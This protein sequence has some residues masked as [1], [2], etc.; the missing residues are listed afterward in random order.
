MIK[1][2]I[3]EYYRWS[4]I[5]IIHLLLSLFVIVLAH[6]VFL[7][8]ITMTISASLLVLTYFFTKVHSRFAY[9]LNVFSTA[10]LG[11]L[12]IAINMVVTG[13]LMLFMLVPLALY[14]AWYIYHYQIYPEDFT[15]QIHN[16]GFLNTKYSIITCLLLCLFIGGGGFI[17]GLTGL[18]VYPFID[19]GIIT[20]FL[21]SI[22]LIYHGKYEHTITYSIYDG[23]NLL[24]WVLMWMHF[25]VG[26]S[27]I[28]VT[29]IVFGRSR[30]LL[31]W[32]V[33]K[34]LKSPPK[35]KKKK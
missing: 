31:V 23:L 26:V 8:P 22:S 14:F 32:W 12:F 28:L 11:V 18:S 33:L 1:L 25:G 34:T 35:K 24:V 7:E 19:L 20:L 9:T 16:N 4:T 30:L 6:V 13:Y 15:S 29:L 3:N 2:L 21:A 5:D 10:S 27:M 17:L